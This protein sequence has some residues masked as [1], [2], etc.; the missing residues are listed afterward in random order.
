MKNLLIIFALWLAT[1]YLFAEPVFKSIA[2][3]KWTEAVQKYDK[4]TLYDYING[5]S[6][7]YFN[8]GF[9]QLWVTEFTK[10]SLS[11][12][13][14]V[15]HHRNPDF[16]YGIFSQE[17]PMSSKGSP[18]GSEGY[19]SGNV[20]N[21][22]IG[23][24]YIKIQGDAI[25]QAQ[26][27]VATFLGEFNRQF[28]GQLTPKYTSW[29]PTEFMVLNSLKYIANEFMGYNTFG[30]GFQ[31]EYQKGNKFYNFFVIP[32]KSNEAALETM[33][34]YFKYLNIDTPKAKE[35]Y[36]IEDQYNGELL[37]YLSDN[38]ILGF[39]GKIG[40]KEAQKII[41]EALSEK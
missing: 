24:Y 11:I 17:R 40:K 38:T 31:A 21:Y 30:G 13:V 8:Y 25:E 33:Q 41:N 28:Q 27:D 7:F 35:L 9:K 37:L 36:K 18:F 22:Y 16:A 20:L 19:I 34:A 12:T 1:F 5:G 14:E 39:S 3:F 26:P 10:D 2:P 6:E 15:Y 23:A 29:F 4:K 32:K